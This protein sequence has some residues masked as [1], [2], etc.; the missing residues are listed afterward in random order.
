MKRLLLIAVGSVCLLSCASSDKRDTF[1]R[2]PAALAIFKSQPLENKDILEASSSGA[3]KASK[4]RI[5]TDN[6]AAFDSKIEA[7]RSAKSGETIRLTYYIYS[8]DASSAVFTDELL[9]AAQ[10]GVKIKLMADLITNYQLLDYFSYLQE[11][12]K[13]QIQIRL[14]GRP[15]SLMIRD[16]MFMTT[17]CPPTGDKKVKATTCSS[18]KWARLDGEKPDFYAQLALSGAYGKN[19]DALQT[20]VLKGQ[21][22]DVKS[23]TSGG[24]TSADDQKQF[25]DFLK[26]L[27]KS[28]L[29]HDFISA[30]K[31]A[32]AYQIYG[33]KLNPIMNQLMGA[34]PISHPGQ[35]S[36][37]DWEHSTDFTHHKLL[38]IGNR[39]VQLGG[40][41]IENS[42]HMKPNDL[43]DKYIFMDT[44]VAATLTSG[45]DTVAK[46]FDEL[47]NFAQMTIALDEVRALMP[48]DFIA[49]KEAS[50]AA[51]EKCTVKDYKTDADRY[52]F[53]QCVSQELPRQP[54]YLNLQAR[55]SKVSEDLSKGVQ[56][57]NNQYASRK[58]YTQTWKTGSGYADEISAKDLS[59]LFMTYVE[60]VPYDRRDAVPD[61]ERTKGSVAGKEM[62][63][64]K[65]IHHLWYKGLE[66]ACT[67]SAKEGKEKRVILHSAYFLPPAIV[68]R[69]FS[70]MMD[71]TWDC[72]NVKVT[73]LTN[74]PE[75][76]DLF[77]VNVAAKYEM[78][79]FF[80]IYAQRKQIYGSFADSRSAKFEYYEY[81]KNTEAKGLSLH[82]KAT[83]LGDDVLIGSANADVRS[84]Y[85]DSN[86]G[87]FIRGA[88]DFVKDY[89]TYIDEI[90]QD[91]MKTRQMTAY[92]S[93]P[94]LSLD[95]LTK[96]DQKWVADLLAKNEKT[97]NLSP[98]VKE[99]VNKLV[100]TMAKFVDATTKKILSKEFIE[101]WAG[102][103]EN[104][105]ESK[106]QQEQIEMEK[107]F[108]RMLQ[109]L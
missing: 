44:D 41:N 48:N 1:D 9:K 106:K 60:N 16:V 90:T 8:E 89:V 59:G 38:M 70:K 83:V 50:K 33:D 109:I 35:S 76:T 85:M 68:L 92:F 65:Y 88:K 84:Y 11:Q 7:I 72:H 67:T 13:G 18:A 12:G 39:Y 100:A 32:L 61:R 22:L 58:S 29:Q 93:N 95:Y 66:N 43:T 47:F 62:K 86:N 81:L 3:L 25:I 54:Q 21:I 107:K 55:L 52:S 26:L 64:G 5:I 4:V 34:I 36:F 69:G 14:Y 101:E 42:Y 57:Y 80:Q 37:T 49:N 15:T 71:G 53:A 82:T 56:A 105:I 87:F 6:D 63:Y 79:A 108:N 94:S 96:G 102:D 24:G 46:S 104:V 23:F 30:V 10:R 98:K 45:G 77:Y 31:V 73:F 19:L 97:K 99:N 17:P 20:A 74:S 75:T 40:R 91:P 27:A 78:A 103:N 28:K 51:V 2:M